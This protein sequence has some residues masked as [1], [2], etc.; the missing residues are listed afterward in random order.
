MNNSLQCGSHT[1]LGIMSARSSTQH[2]R[3]AVPWWRAERPCLFIRPSCWDC[4]F[5]WNSEVFLFV[6][7]ATSVTTV[8][9]LFSRLSAWF[10][11]GHSG[12]PFPIFFFFLLAA[13]TVLMIYD[14]NFLELVQW[15][16]RSWL[17]Y[18]NPSDLCS[19]VLNYRLMETCCGLL[20]PIEIRSPPQPGVI[21][22]H[23]QHP[24]SRSIGIDLQ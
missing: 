10:T 7:H 16:E 20:L 12:T 11:G 14:R 24:G 3:A 13:P 21:L 22:I 5:P 23:I 4:I 18:I 2:D 8:Q 9:Y 15:Q 1:D 19:H 17:V 6:E